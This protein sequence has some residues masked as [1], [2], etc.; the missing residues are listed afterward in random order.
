[1]N[2]RISPRKILQTR[3]IFEDEF[4]EEFLY[5]TSTDISVSGIFI[6]SK[7]PFKSGTK[8]FLRFSLYEGDDPIRVTGEV[9]RFIDKKRGPGRRR[10][11]TAGVGLKFLGLSDADFL[12]VKTYVETH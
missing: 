8:V 2:N 12:R 9:M 5:F 4:N 1:M 3:V 6:Q 7:L 10:P 11:V